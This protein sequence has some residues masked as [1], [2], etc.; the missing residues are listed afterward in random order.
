MVRAG[1]GGFVKGDRIFVYLL[2][3][4]VVVTHPGHGKIE[5]ASNRQASKDSSVEFWA[6]FPFRTQDEFEQ[7]RSE[8]KQ[9]YLGMRVAR[10]E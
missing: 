7:F 8:V 2:D 6:R 5:S 9:F 3:G 10:P 4:G 1:Y